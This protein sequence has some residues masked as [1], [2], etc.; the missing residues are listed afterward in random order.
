PLEAA[1]ALTGE[2]GPPKP[3]RLASSCSSGPLTQL[4]T[5]PSYLP[6]PKKPVRYSPG[7]VVNRSW[8]TRRPNGC[9]SGSVSANDDSAP[10]DTCIRTSPSAASSGRRISPVTDG[11]IR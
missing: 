3:R 4:T 10:L 1:R 6:G 2:T 8:Q 5:D 11:V 9:S 7:D